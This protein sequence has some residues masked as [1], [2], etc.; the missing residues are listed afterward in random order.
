MSRHKN[1]WNIDGIIRNIYL[2]EIIFLGLIG[3]CFI[4][5]LIGY[6]S[7]RAVLFYWLTMTP[8][9]F[10]SSVISEKAAALQSGRDTPHF[11]K[12]EAIFWL[13]AFIA[14]MLIMLLWHASIIE[15]EATGL[16]IHIILAHTMLLT[17][18]LLGIRF[19]LI[20]FFLFLTAGLTIA[21]E[22][23]V[24]RSV[25]IAVPVIILGLYYEKYFLFPSIRNK[26][27]QAYRGDEI[28][29]DEE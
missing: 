18:T 6:L 15:T 12:Y 4:G 11:L 13:S 19:Y 22:G 3:L 21:V 23:E 16:I 25:F 7:E 24:G 17:G 27:E 9:F 2:N 20:G 14:V 26:I 10:I 8:I 28:Y 5:D 29:E 1:P